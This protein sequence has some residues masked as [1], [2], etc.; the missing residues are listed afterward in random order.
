[1][2][3]PFSLPPS[4]GQ[5]FLCFQSM[6]KIVREKARQY[7]AYIISKCFFW[8][9]TIVQNKQKCFTKLSLFYFFL[10]PYFPVVSKRYWG[11]RT[12]WSSSVINIRKV[13]IWL[14]KMQL[15]K[16]K[17]VQLSE[18]KTQSRY[19]ASQVLSSL[20]KLDSSDAVPSHFQF[21]KL[22]GKIVTFAIFKSLMCKLWNVF[23][24]TM[25][26]ISR[27]CSYE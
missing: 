10:A 9:P 26:S 25:F 6:N 19:E 1:M 4:Y 22:K 3:F 16:M 15:H 7:V 13:N 12:L 24:S 23:L 21:K 5:L 14:R 27:M 18:G 20:V 8:L 17:T 11:N 2:S